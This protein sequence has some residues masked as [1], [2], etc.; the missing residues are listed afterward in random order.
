MEGVRIFFS[1]DIKHETEDTMTEKVEEALE[2]EILSNGIKYEPGN[3][4]PWK[5]PRSCDKCGKEFRSKGHLQRHVDGVHHKLKGYK[6]DRCDYEATDRR[7]VER[8][9]AIVHENQRPTFTCNICSH[10]MRTLAALKSHDARRHKELPHC[11]T[12]CHYKTSDKATLKK[13]IAAV[14][15]GIRY[16]CHL[17]EYKASAKTVKGIICLGFTLVLNFNVT[18]VIIKLTFKVISFNTNKPSTNLVQNSSATG[19]IIIHSVA[20]I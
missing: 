9:K 4:P 3:V 12:S 19:A 1:S 11:C 8:H 6:C 5:L 2:V 15:E 13:H 20:T 10:Q 16:P 7:Y 17:C 18:N 14:H